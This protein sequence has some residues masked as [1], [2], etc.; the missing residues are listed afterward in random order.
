LQDI[1]SIEHICKAAGRP[2]LGVSVD[3]LKA[4]CGRI[5]GQVDIVDCVDDSTS[6]WFFGKYGFV[7][8]NPVAFECQVPF[9]GALGF[10]DVP[11]D[12]LSQ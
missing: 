12:Y 8:R 10:F 6:P 1:N 4:G 7:L 11:D 2:F 9:K 5:V 3:Y